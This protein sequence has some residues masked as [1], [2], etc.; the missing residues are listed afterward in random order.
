MEKQFGGFQLNNDRIY[1]YLTKM[2]E[3]LP[4]LHP[5]CDELLKY[6]CMHPKAFTDFWSNVIDARLCQRKGEHKKKLLCFNL[7]FRLIEI[8]KSEEIL[9]NFNSKNLFNAYLNNYLN[10]TNLHLIVKSMHKNLVELYEKKEVEF[11][12]KNKSPIFDFLCKFV[13]LKLQSNS[14]YELSDFLTAF[15]VNTN[16]HGIESVFNLFVKCMDSVRASTDNLDLNQFWILNQ[17]STLCVNPKLLANKAVTNNLLEFLFA[18]S[19]FPA[20]E[21]C[22]VNSDS[23]KTFEVV[24]EVLFKF[25]SIILSK[26]TIDSNRILFKFFIDFLDGQKAKLFKQQLK[27]NDFHSAWKKI[28]NL[29]KSL[30]N[31]TSGPGANDETSNQKKKFDLFFVLL[32][33]QLLKLVESSTYKMVSNDIDDLNMAYEKS[34]LKMESIKEGWS[35]I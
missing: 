31:S 22:L 23:P 15:I 11:S 16:E 21:K 6:L 25:I 12:I 3:Y 19:F 1:E 27:S 13:D 35:R 18:N 9:T 26:F 32:T 7:W 14:L 8:T 10:N 33:F 29:M 24:K 2:T 30:I 4:K 17:M 34:N 5:F 20:H 28:V